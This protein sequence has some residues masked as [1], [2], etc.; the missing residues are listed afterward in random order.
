M[1]QE[2]ILGHISNLVPPAPYALGTQRNPVNQYLAFIWPDQPDNQIG[3]GA[4]SGAR[5]TNDGSSLASPDSQVKIDKYLMVV[6]A[7]RYPFNTDGLS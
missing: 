5:R 2:R 4:L 3:E 7:K 1:K 6:V